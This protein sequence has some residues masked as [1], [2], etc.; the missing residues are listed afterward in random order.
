M[1]GPHGLALHSSTTLDAFHHLTK[2][3]IVMHTYYLPSEIMNKI[4]ITIAFCHII[5]VDQSVCQSSSTNK[6]TSHECVWSYHSWI[7]VVEGTLC[8]ASRQLCINLS[9]DLRLS[10]LLWQTQTIKFLCCILSLGLFFTPDRK[11]HDR[12]RPCSTLFYFIL[13]I[14]V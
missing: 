7:Q 12:A 5:C 11:L 2:Q 13:T 1:L 4:C 3:Y 6:C 8:L 14:F 10:L 9:L